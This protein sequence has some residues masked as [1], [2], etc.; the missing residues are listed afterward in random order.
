MTFKFFIFETWRNLCKKWSQVFV[1]LGM[2]TSI[3]EIL[4]HFPQL[5]FYKILNSQTSFYVVV[6]CSIIYLLIKIW[7]QTSF[8]QR[9]K[10]TDI[11]VGFKIGDILEVKEDDII[12]PTN[13]TFDTSLKRDIISRHS[14]RGQFLI[15]FFKEETKQIDAMIS[16]NLKGRN[17]NISSKKN[18]G[19][20]ARYSI[21]ETITIKIPGQQN[22]SYW[23]AIAEMNQNCTAHSSLPVLTQA[24]CSLWNY[25]NSNGEKNNLVIPIMGSGMARIP[26]TKNKLICEI[27]QSFIVANKESH[28]SKKLTVYLHPKD[29]NDIDIEEVKEFICYQAKFAYPSTL[30]FPINSPGIP[31]T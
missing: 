25:I 24:L 10:N 20:K 19:K 9:I 11:H 1:P 29:L 16:Q 2:Y 13:T 7:P 3:L 14:I 27:F 22:C 21:G 17:K 12:I 23:V 5:E 18:K 6:A 4:T 15:R 28:F 30:E 26:A 31:T 8:Y